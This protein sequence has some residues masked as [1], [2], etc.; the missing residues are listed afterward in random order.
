MRDHAEAQKWILKPCTWRRGA[1]YRKDVEG[2]RAANTTLER[3][4]LP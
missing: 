1:V 4:V 2:V 3:L